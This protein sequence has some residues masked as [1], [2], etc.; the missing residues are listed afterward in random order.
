MNYQSIKVIKKTIFFDIDGTLA[1]IE[2]RRKYLNQNRP[3]WRRFNAAMGDD[4][5]NN[6]VVNLYHSLLKS[7]DYDIIIVTGRS[8]KF[9]P[10]TETWFAWHE[11]PFSRI[12]MRAD[13]DNRPDHIIK[14]EILDA[15]IAEGREIA[16]T[17]DDRNQV[18][19][20]WRRRGITCFQ[21]APGNF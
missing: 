7:G 21:C 10:V 15:L 20:M 12:L 9:R 19:D 4:K 8:E 3:D 11:I 18:V 2:H 13:G 6:D 14:E 1:D 16:F 5:P 17:V